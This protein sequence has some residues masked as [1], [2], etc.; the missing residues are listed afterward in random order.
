MLWGKNSKGKGWID[1]PRQWCVTCNSYQNSYYDTCKERCGNANDCQ[2]R[3]SNCHRLFCG[4]LT[5][6]S[7]SSALTGI[8]RDER[9]AVGRALDEL[10]DQSGGKNEYEYKIEVSALVSRW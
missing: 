10:V 9:L 7:H 5:R 4:A 6:P 2:E 1:M 3:C 8:S